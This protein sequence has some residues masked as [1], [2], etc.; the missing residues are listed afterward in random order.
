MAR[1]LGAKMVEAPY[2]Y[3]QRRMVGPVRLRCEYAGNELV[4]FQQ[5]KEDVNPSMV[6]DHIT[7]ME[8]FD[9]PYRS[10]Y[11]KALKQTSSTAFMGRSQAREL[12]MIK[13]IVR[14]QAL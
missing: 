13:L 6:S 2:Q 12:S 9:N 3:V 7:R 5:S 10:E 14:L 11:E 8:K 1:E 4:L